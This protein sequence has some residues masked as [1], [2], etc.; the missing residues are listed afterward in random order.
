MARHSGSRLVQCYHCRHRF[1][2]GG[3]TRSTS[4]PNCNKPVIVEDI[5]VKSG[6]RG[7]LREDRTCGKVIV[8]KRG[9][10]LAHHLEAHGGIECE[11][12]LEAR[13]II[14]G[15]PVTIG[16]KATFKGDLS[17]PALTIKLGAKLGASDLRIPDD[18]LGL[19]DL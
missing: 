6:V 18:P 11:G 16:P 3:R 5:V 2:V 14:S 15:K 13:T 1:E 8:G 7:P 12:V 10:L 17:A 9:R 4:C 19:G